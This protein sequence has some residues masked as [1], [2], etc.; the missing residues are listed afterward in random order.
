MADSPTSFFDFDDLFDAEIIVDRMTGGGSL[1]AETMADM[2]GVVPQSLA[3]LTRRGKIPHPGYE[4]SDTTDVQRVWSTE[5]AAVALIVHGREPVRP[6][7]TDLEP[8]GTRA[9]Y[10]RHR[11][12]NE[13]PCVACR[14]AKAAQN[15]KYRTRRTRQLVVA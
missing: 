9:A 7:A 15:N 10:E 11:R 12:H 5:R 13:P 3:T 14:E 1:D 8:C 2:L 4:L 6:S